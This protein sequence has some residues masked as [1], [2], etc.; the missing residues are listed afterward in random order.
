MF[1]AKL[2]MTIGECCEFLTDKTN[3]KMIE[4]IVLI[5]N[6]KIRIEKFE[7]VFIS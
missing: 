4:E 7:E 2:E 5:E 6:K 1:L 3:K